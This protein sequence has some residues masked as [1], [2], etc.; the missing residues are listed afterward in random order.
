MQRSAPQ[1][2][3]VQCIVVQCSAVHCSAVQCSALHCSASH[4]RAHHGVAPIIWPHRG[5]QP[6]AYKYLSPGSWLN[7]YNLSSL[8]LSL[9]RCQYNFYLLVCQ[10]YQSI[11]LGVLYSTGDQE[12]G[13]YL[14]CTDCTIV[15]Y[16]RTE[17]DT[18]LYCTPVL[19][20]LFTGATQMAATPTQ[21]YPR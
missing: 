17:Y 11:V 12:F 18:L 15:L 4:G 21:W 8:A 6:S 14:N 3:T 9:R 7:I 19:T 16:S 13:I 5:T 20:V 2:S 10:S 1:C